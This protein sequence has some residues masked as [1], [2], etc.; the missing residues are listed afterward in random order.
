MEQMMKMY[1]LSGMPMGDMPVPETLVLNLNN[2]LVKYLIENKDA[3]NR[4]LICEQLY[5]LAR[6]ANKPLS[7]DDMSKFIARSTKLM[8]SVINR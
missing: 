6:I 4:K 2:P 8:E 5:D 1:S 3:H 7:T